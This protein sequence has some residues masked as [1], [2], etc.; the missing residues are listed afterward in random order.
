M[1]LLAR[2]A[3]FV[4][5]RHPFALKP[6]LTSLK[7]LVAATSDIDALREP[8]RKAL[9]SSLALALA[10]DVE[11]GNV[12][13]TT[14]GVNV[15]E[16]LH[17]A[18]REVID[19]SDGFLRREAIAASLSKTLGRTAVAHVRVNPDIVG[20]V[21]VRVGDYVKDGSVRR[22]LGLLKSKQIGRASCRE[23]V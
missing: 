4:A 5:E 16:R 14:P 3:A 15:S 20:G 13:E 7:P 22:S 9:E 19:A 6:A 1:T 2:Y 23:R 12:P 18:V 8:L 21:I 10:P 11:V 17:Q